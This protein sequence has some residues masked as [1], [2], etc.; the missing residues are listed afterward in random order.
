MVGIH[1]TL[2][3][4]VIL[5]LIGFT[6]A[7]LMLTGKVNFSQMRLNLAGSGDGKKNNLKKSKKEQKKDKKSKFNKST[8]AATSVAASATIISAGDL[9]DD[10]EDFGSIDDI[11]NDIDLSDFEDLDFDDME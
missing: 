6:F 4:I 5:N 7:I 2:I 8:A 11:I 9:M 3:T 10:D 1:I